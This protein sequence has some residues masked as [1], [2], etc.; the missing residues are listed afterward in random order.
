MFSNLQIKI[1]YMLPVNFNR[2]MNN[3]QHQLNIQQT[4]M[5]DITPY[6]NYMKL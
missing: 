2:I 5:V 4:S 3:L 1:I 6:R